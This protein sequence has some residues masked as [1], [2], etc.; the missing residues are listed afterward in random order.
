MLPTDV[1]V[2]P[3]LK[4]AWL[5][6]A[7]TMAI[8]A[9]RKTEFTVRLPAAP[10]EVRLIAPGEA[11]DGVEPV[12]ICSD[13]KFTVPTSMPAVSRTDRVQVPF[14]AAPDRPLKVAREP[15]GRNDP[16]NGVAP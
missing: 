9:V 4:A 8:F 2:I 11:R 13:Q 12:R 6:A 7:S 10:V 14:A 15:V 5:P 3:P 1:K 16:A